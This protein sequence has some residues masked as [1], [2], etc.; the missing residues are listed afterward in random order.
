ML[1]Y[2][3]NSHFKFSVLFFS[4]QHWLCKWQE[5][6]SIGSFTPIVICDVG[7]IFTYKAHNND[8]QRTSSG[9]CTSIKANAAEMCGWTLLFLPIVPCVLFLGC[10]CS[11]IWHSWENNCCLTLQITWLVPQI[12]FLGFHISARKVRWWRVWKSF[13]LRY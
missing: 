10:S 5:P 8:S 11:W 4:H 3:I 9:E 7:S 2:Y 12:S 13:T 1:W 6:K